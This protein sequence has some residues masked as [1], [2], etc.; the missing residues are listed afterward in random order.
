M[1][2]LPTLK[3]QATAAV[4]QRRE[5]LLELSR[6]IHQHP[7][8]SF[9]ETQAAGWLSEFLDQEGFVV[10]RGV[11]ELPTAFRAERGS[12]PVTIGILAEY[13][14]LPEVGHACG[15]NI[16]GTCAVGAAVAAAEPLAALGARVVVYGTPAEEVGGGKVLMAERGAFRDLDL[17]LIVHPGNRNLVMARSLACV[18]LDVEFFGKAAHAAARP[19]AGINALDAL[20]LAFNGI[21]ALRQHI[22]S[23]AR[24]HGI[25]T[26]GGAAP[27]VVPEYSAARFLVRAADDP[28]L[29]ELKGRVQSIFEGA[30]AMTGARLQLDWG[31]EARYAALRTNEPLAWAFAANLEALGR[32]LAEPEPG[33]S[34]GSTDMG[35]VSAIVPSIHPA[36]AIGDRDL[37]GH[38]PEFAAAAGSDAGAAAVIDAA[39]ALALT[40]LD[41]A[42]DAELLA[43]IRASFADGR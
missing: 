39:K 28:Y 29:D 40:A 15:H 7:E 3:E 24:I 27:N 21:N 30:A 2:D 9:E 19:E 18:S 26:H 43:R 14:A 5:R 42:A 41:V 32:E 12:G 36:I 33:R 31:G 17:A 16:M 37:V 10:E 1:P 20:L 11:Y 35:N 23:D 38:T 6:R 34:L 8:L 25:I 4:E 22:R 13:D